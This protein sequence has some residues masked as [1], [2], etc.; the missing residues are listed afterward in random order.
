LLRFDYPADAVV[1]RYFREHRQLGHADRA[2]VA[3]TVFAAAPWPQPGSAL[4][5][6][7]V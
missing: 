1:S 7:A 6:Q 2:F 4:R 5:R 3:E